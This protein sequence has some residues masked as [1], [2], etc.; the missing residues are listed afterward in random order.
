MTFAH[1]P[2]RS[3]DTPPSVARKVFCV[4][5]L[6]VLGLGIFCLI[7]GLLG[8]WGMRHSYE[9]EVMCPEPEPCDTAPVSPHVVHMG[10]CRQLCA[11]GVKSYV[12]RSSSGPHCTC[13]GPRR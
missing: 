12:Y 6:I 5:K 8:G 7:V 1:G 9:I 13:Y 3:P 4:E 10:A 11:Y 2:Y